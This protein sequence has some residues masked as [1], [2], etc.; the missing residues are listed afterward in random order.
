MDSK[1]APTY[2]PEGPNHY[3]TCLHMNSDDAG[4]SYTINN[5]Y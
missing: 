5:V 2:T 1:Y 3:K 4:C